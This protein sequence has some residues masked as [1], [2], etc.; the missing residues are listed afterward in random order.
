[1]S[2]PK[3]H[4]AETNRLL[5][6]VPKTKISK[7]LLEEGFYPEQYVIPPCLR[8]KKFKLQDNPYFEVD[9]SG[10]Q[11]KFEPEKGDLI[12]V[13]FPKTQLTDRTFG[14][15]AP[16]IYHDLVW[17]LMDE[18]DLVIKTLFKNQ[19]KIY[20]YSFPIPVSKKNE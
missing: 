5:K 2:L 13:S 1:M 4:N 14:I 9:T 10:A 6:K 16:K 12:N 11:P 7:W 17:H 3:K 20:S 15:I 19:N 8:I 18:W